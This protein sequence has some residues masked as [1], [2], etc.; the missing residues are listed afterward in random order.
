MNGLT[1][2][3]GPSALVLATL[4]VSPTAASVSLPFNGATYS[5]G[6]EPHQMRAADVNGDGML[7]LVSVT[8]NEA[9][10]DVILGRGDGMFEDAVHH[11]AGFRHGML[12][13]ADFDGDGDIDVA[14]TS[15]PDNVV[16]ILFN[17]GDGV[18]EDLTFY[19][20]PDAPGTVTV[21]D[22]N[23]DGAPDL[24]IAHLFEADISVLLNDGAGGFTTLD[25]HPLDSVVRHVSAFD[26]DGDGDD[27]LALTCEDDQRLHILYAAGDGVLVQGPQYEL[28]HEGLSTDV[29][30]ID[31]DGRPDLM[32]STVHENGV[33]SLLGRGDGT[34]GDP[35][36]FST[37][38]GVGQL[39]LVDYDLD[40]DLD[41]VGGS[42]SPYRP[43]LHL[44]ENHGEGVF[45]PVE[46]LDPGMEISTLAIGDL[47]GD[48]APDIITGSGSAGRLTVFLNDNGH[49]PGQDIHDAPGGRQ[50]GA[51]GDF[52]ADGWIDLAIANT[53]NGQVRIWRNDQAG[54]LHPSG[55]F[56]I[57]SE[58]SDITAADLDRDGDLD[59]AVT[60]EEE[61]AVV[62][63]WNDGGAGFSGHDTY[64][65]SEGLIALVAV[66]LNGDG[67]VDLAVSEPNADRLSFLLND[68]QGGLA[69]IK[70]H[71]IDNRPYRLAAGDFDGDAVPDIAVS[72]ADDDRLHI[73]LNHGDATFDESVIEVPYLYRNP[74]VSAD[75][76]GDGD[77][78]LAFLARG[79]VLA[80]NDGLGEFQPQ[81]AIDIPNETS[82][83]ASTDLDGDGD[84]DLL[85][86]G[87]ESMYNG[88]MTVM[89]NEGDGTFEIPGIFAG[90]DGTFRPVAADFDRDGDPDVAL[91]DRIRWQLTILYNQYDPCYGDL[92][93]DGDVDSEDLG[94]LLAAYEVDDRGDIDGDGL[95]G[96][97]DLGLLLANFGRVC[98]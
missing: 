96:Q 66:D 54:F 30:D 50:L 68:G 1:R 41:V 98:D 24:V 58:A 73:L 13:I 88:G 92:D 29:G 74:I 33:A 67:A 80:I 28:G 72:S 19:Q 27:D 57:G 5:G 37:R 93:E 85:I 22:P 49:Y 14:A 79:L 87:G 18:Y 16:S 52:D 59:L 95:T 46:Y 65:L 90:G 3:S 62:V 64:T 26:F 2:L 10:L 84:A 47:N 38:R 82:G 60:D 81:D 89:L 69:T 61:G 25:P 91:P 32:V 97:P 76:D 23:G 71:A 48:L 4:I 43:G 45:G 44:L 21:A 70:E 51:A 77:L 7:D 94:I 8:V 55:S 75:M 56:P 31:R 35:T 42:Y 86:P 78:D 39:R 6:Y 34:F 36:W 63:L 53:F 11:D 15:W 83:L 9:V 17:Q 20:T 12:A 40:E